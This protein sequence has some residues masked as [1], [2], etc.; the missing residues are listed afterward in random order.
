[1]FFVHFV[2]DT[3]GKG[4]V[5]AGVASL[6]A[7]GI[8]KEFNT[9]GG[10]KLVSYIVSQVVNK[11]VPVSPTLVSSRESIPVNNRGTRSVRIPV[12]DEGVHGIRGIRPLII[13][14]VVELNFKHIISE[15]ST[16]GLVEARVGKLGVQAE[17]CSSVFRFPLQT[18]KVG[19]FA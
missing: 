12:V 3:L 18:T 14:L 16:L 6:H 4:G 15:G 19:S 13:D 2:G 17:V 5:E 8:G 10:R 7:F 11:A 9:A 1:M